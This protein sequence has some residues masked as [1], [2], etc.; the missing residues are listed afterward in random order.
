MDW[1]G[2]FTWVAGEL[3]DEIWGTFIWNLGEWLKD[4]VPV[5]GPLGTLAV[6]GVA[7]VAYLQKVTADKRAQWWTRAEWAM[8]TALEH[9]PQ[10]RETGVIVLLGLSGSSLAT[11]EDKELIADVGVVIL[12]EV[13]GDLGEDENSDNDDEPLDDDDDV[14]E[15]EEDGGEADGEST[16]PSIGRKIGSLWRAAKGQAA[17]ARGSQRAQVSGE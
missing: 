8:Q 14:V 11:P 2:I 16:K 9:D 12:D 17:K 3:I 1:W 13:L 10:K 7:F 15:T 4:W 5:L 6:A